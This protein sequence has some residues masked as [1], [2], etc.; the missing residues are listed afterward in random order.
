MEKKNWKSQVRQ[1]EVYYSF[2]E[3]NGALDV[4]ST[5]VH[6]RD[7]SIEKTDKLVSTIHKDVYE[8]LTKWFEQKKNSRK[9]S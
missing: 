6:D 8:S 3:N 4:Y 2:K 9:I 1:K 5:M 7:G